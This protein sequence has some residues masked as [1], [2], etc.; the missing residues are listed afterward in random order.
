MNAKQMDAMELKLQ[1]LSPGTGYNPAKLRMLSILWLVLA[2]ALVSF[3]TSAETPL[4][5]GTEETLAEPDS[6]I[7][8]KQSKSSD[9][10]MAERLA[11]IYENIDP[12]QPVQVQVEDGVVVLTGTLGSLAAVERAKSLAERLE[13]TVIVDNQLQVDRRLKSRLQVT[14]EKLKERVSTFISLVPLLLVA[15][16]IIVAFY[17]LGRWV[18]GMTALFRYLSPNTF[19]AQLMG[20]LVQL[21]IIVAGLVLALQ[22]TGAEGALASVAGGLGIVGLALSFATRDTIENYIASVLLSLKQ[23]FSP[24]DH[25]IVAD[26]EG[27]VMRL[28]SRATILMSF[29]GN[30]IRIPNSSVYKS[31]IVNFS[32]NPQRRFD[33][34]V[35][36]STE[37]DLTKARKLAVEALEDMHGVLNDPAPKCVVSGFGDS[38]MQLKVLGWVDQREADFSKVKSEAIRNV[39]A[40]FEEADIAMPNPIYDIQFHPD[41]ATTIEHKD[42][43]KD[44]TAPHKTEDT[45]TRKDQEPAEQAAPETTAEDVR[46][47]STIEKQIAEEQ[48][49]GEDNLLDPVAPKE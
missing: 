47:D 1:T 43:N 10:Q 42:S 36:V 49:Q 3:N 28:T 15:I 4:F 41:G 37:A 19:I 24:N 29:D 12:L 9:Q 44:I 38:S 17:L 2:F 16:V 22:V 23:P 32:R 45:T 20:Q 26:Q 6:T 48:E 31:I 46:L 8:P 13:G 27:L 33:F 34:V 35:G 21:V 11:K 25:V 40:R 39:K 18:G 7:E 5:A 14:L 30:H